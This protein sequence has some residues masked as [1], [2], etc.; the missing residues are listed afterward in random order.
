MYEVV[1]R[2]SGP[3]VWVLHEEQVSQAA[4][5]QVRGW[6][7]SDISFQRFY[8]WLL[9]GPYVAFV[10]A[11]FPLER[12]RFRL[13]TALNLVTCLAFIVVCHW[14][15]VRTRESF[16]K[17][18]VIKVSHAGENVQ[19]TGNLQRAGQSAVLN[20]PQ[21]VRGIPARPFG[22]PELS[23]WS[24]L[25]DLLAYA[26][27]VG[28]VHSFHF[29]SR[30]REREHRTLVLESNL[31]AARLSTLRA[32]LQPHF[33]FNSLNAVA[34]LLRRDPRLAEATLLSLSELLRIALTQSERQET[35]LREELE[36]VDRYLE[37]QQTRFEDKLTVKQEIEQEAL[38][39]FVPTLLLQP[40]VENAIR[41]GIEPAESTCFVRVTA[42]RNHGR[43]LL[44]VEDNGV[45]LSDSA[46]EPRDGAVTR[47]GR[48]F[49][50]TDARDGNGIGL[51]NLRARLQALYGR[52]QRLELLSRS[53][54]GVIVRVEIPW[55]TEEG[56]TCLEKN[57][58]T[59]SE[60]F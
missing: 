39:C 33:L 11:F 47:S 5:R 49:D 10:A 55:R 29:Y 19:A 18:R 14:M 23:F 21:E 44:A 50:V 26:A 25:L 12:G 37:I 13:R 2:G 42:R 34:A 15:N 8:P 54:G 27:V 3:A 58:V 53:G 36:F 20:L 46:A 4:T 52:E 22:R 7:R 59:K 43:L 24:T 60:R 28:L 16:P 40:V 57:S 35:L 45:G 1:Q 56:A 17:I 51:R 48:S 9:F 32:Q 6:F 31:A 38:G 41:H 30:F